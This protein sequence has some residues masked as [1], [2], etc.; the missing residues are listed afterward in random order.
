[1]T[2]SKRTR[3]T[4][5]VCTRERP[6]ELERLIA[7]I[8]RQRFC[9]IDRPDVDL[10][11]V[12][13]SPRGGR[14]DVKLLGELA[15]WPVRIV[16]E[17]RIGVAHA[18]NTA[19]TNR[20]ADAEFL[21]SVDDDQ[22]VA[23]SWLD[24]LLAYAESTRAPVV[25]GPVL[26]KIPPTTPEWIAML[27]RN[28][29]RRPTGTSMPSFLGGNVCFRSGLFDEIGSWYDT[30]HATST[31]DD[32]ELG[33]RLVALGYEIEW[34][35]RAVA[36]EHIPLAR[37]QTRWVAERYLSF[38]GFEAIQTRR[39]EGTT[40]LIRETPRRLGDLV[41]GIALGA[42]SLGN[43]GRRARAFSTTFATLGWLGGVAGWRI[44]DYRRV[45]S[46]GGSVRADLAA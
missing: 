33:R 34:C 31:A 30:T 32:A 7:S 44:S 24:H 3:V 17:P 6:L 36:W 18:R 2:P 39:S 1:V 28:V 38:G 45:T 14:L 35:D 20:A 16:T 26:V 19:I 5:S 27:W 37:V 9:L 4:I 13:N 46:E 43:P 23:P 29:P 22:T 21:V 15:T 42:A 11:V 10:V 40:A 25:T 41:E 8:G 12:D